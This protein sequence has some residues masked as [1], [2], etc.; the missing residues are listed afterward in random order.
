MARCKRSNH[1]D[2]SLHTV[3]AKYFAHCDIRTSSKKA[4][5]EEYL[6]AA[7]LPALV[8]EDVKAIDEAGMKLHFRGFVSD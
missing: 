7:D 5:L 2:V 8:P 6:A 4:R 3:A 1:C